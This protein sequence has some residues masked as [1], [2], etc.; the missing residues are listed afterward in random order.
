MTSKSEQSRLADEVYYNVAELTKVPKKSKLHIS[1]GG[2]QEDEEKE[3]M[4]IEAEEE[5]KSPHVLAASS[6]FSIR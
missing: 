6:S 1:R 4:E 2:R 5:E 3:M